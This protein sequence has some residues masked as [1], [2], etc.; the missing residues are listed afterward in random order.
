LF[1][2]KRVYSVT[3][4]DSPFISTV[5]KTPNHAMLLELLSG[6]SYKWSLIGNAL[7]IEENVIQNIKNEESIDKRRLSRV[8]SK[9]INS[10]NDVTWKKIVTVI[11]G[12]TVD[13]KA[14]ANNIKEFLNT[15]N[16]L[17]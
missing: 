12:P 5:S 3:N 13:E 10:N 7:Q 14:T 16:I 15:H 17:L 4:V 11:E 2:A 1:L 9:W 8:L 6:I